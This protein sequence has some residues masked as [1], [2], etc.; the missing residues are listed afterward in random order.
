MRK[1]SVLE[2]V[3][4]QFFLITKL[5]SS[6][7]IPIPKTLEDFDCREFAAEGTSFSSF[8]Y[9]ISAVRCAA[10]AISISP[11]IAAKEDSADM[12]Q[13]A[14]SIIDGWS[15]LLP[16]DRRQVMTRNGDIDEL[17]FQAHLLIHV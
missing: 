12:I 6:Q 9:L 17:M 4:A 16:R 1:K 10:L 7:K 14:D 15:L 2:N 11:K 5:I 3:L 8:A 13:S